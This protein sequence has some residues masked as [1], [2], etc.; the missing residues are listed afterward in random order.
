MSSSIATSILVAINIIILIC[1]P[2]G[3]FFA[4]KYFIRYNAQLKKKSHQ[5]EEL[6]KMNIDDL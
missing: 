4:I 1:I 3:I 2:V 5:Q 6:T